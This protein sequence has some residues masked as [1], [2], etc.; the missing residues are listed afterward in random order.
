MAQYAPHSASYIP[1]YVESD[2]VPEALS[3]GSLHEV[4]HTS[5]YWPAAIVGNW[6]GRLYDVAY[7]LVQAKIEDISSHIREQR[8]RAEKRALETK[9]LSERTKILSITVE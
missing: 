4:D 5:L 8:R 2:D 9:T 3:T 1:L 7:P 6:A